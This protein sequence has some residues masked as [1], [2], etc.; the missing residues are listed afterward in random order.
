[1]SMNIKTKYSL[2]SKTTDLEFLRNCNFENLFSFKFLGL[3]YKTLNNEKNQ[4]SQ[5]MELGLLTSQ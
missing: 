3:P 2:K 5:G 4:I 1:M